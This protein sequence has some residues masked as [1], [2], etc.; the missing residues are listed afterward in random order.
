MIRN[1]LLGALRDFKRHKGYS[2]INI[3]GLTVGIVCFILMVLWVQDE[4]SF[5]RY[6]ENANEIYRVIGKMNMASKT[7]LLVRTPNALG[8]ALKNEFPEI[9]NFTRS[10]VVQGW[11]VQCGEK[12]FLDDYIAWADASIFD[13]FTYNFVKG[14]PKTVFNDMHSVVI[15]ERLAKKYFADEDPMGKIISISND[16]FKV[17]GIIKNIPDNSS[18]FFDCIF[19][20]SNT[21]AYHHIDLDAWKGMRM[22]STYIQLQKNSSR[23]E[24]EKKIPGIIKKHDPES[25]M[26]IYLQPLTDIHLK[27]KF[28]ADLYNYNQGDIIYV[29]LLSIV[30]LSILFIACFNYMNLSTARSE[31][32]AKG[33]AIRKVAGASR[34]DIVKQFLGE[35]I[36]LSLIALIFA[37]ILV[38]YLLPVFNSLSGK[39][40]TFGLLGRLPFLLG[41]VALAVV[42]GIISGSYPAFLLSSFRPAAMLKGSGSTQK[43]RGAYL[44]KTLVVVQF[45]VAIVLILSTVVIYAQ[46]VF[47]RTKD[48]GFNPHNVVVFTAAHQLNQDDEGKKAL[49]MSNPNVLN[50]CLADAPM[51]L[52]ERETDDVN[53]EGKNPGEK[54][55]VYP[56]RIDYGYIE[57]YQ[58]KL[59]EGRSFSKEFATDTS[60]YILN[61]TAVKM[62]GYKSPLGKRFWVNGREGTIIGVVKD[63]HHRSLYGKIIPAVLMV[64]YEFGMASIRISPVNIAETIRFL[65]NIWNQINRGPYPFSYTFVDEKIANLYKSEQKI[66]AIA[67]LSTLITLVVS[68]LGL[69]GLA[70]YTS[71]QRTKEIGIRKISGASVSGMVWLISKGFV[72]LA[73]VGLIIACPLAWYGMDKWLQNFAYRINIQWWM[74]VFTG[75]VALAIAFLTVSFQVIKAARANPIDSLRYE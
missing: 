19:P 67:Q 66:G 75:V 40:L 36:I 17:T 44:R 24:L 3:S 41:M 13:M 45:T 8:P 63:F 71:R 59:V 5:D 51:F 33:I 49:F 53:W 15:T 52:S 20:I 32:R 38:Y 9:I 60:A 29:Y 18:F 73:A 64:P 14:N 28:E 11:P 31:D 6:H 37:V 55:T 70:L 21:E 30:A 1:Y 56:A 47:L 12:K 68:C 62:T 25:N 72:Q 16:D 48:L 39:H 57:L 23:K 50:L 54:F 61:E 10:R 74:F 27:S 43:K 69:F 58:M 22:F 26:D 4:L 34:M 7:N 42:T 65:E 2:F 46:L 35:A